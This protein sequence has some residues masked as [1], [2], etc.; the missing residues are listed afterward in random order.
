L[1]DTAGGLMNQDGFCVRS[2]VTVDA[3][4]R[5]FRTRNPLRAGVDSVFVVDRKERLLG[6]M[7][8]AHLATAPLD[9][10]TRDLLDVRAVAVKPSMPV[11]EVINLF[12]NRDLTSVAV[13]GNRGELLGQ[14]TADQVVDVMR[15]QD[16]VALRR[17]GHISARTDFFAGVFSAFVQR[18]PWLGFGLL[19]AILT[20]LIVVQ[21]ER[22]LRAAGEVAAL[23]VVVASLAGVFAVQTAL[24]TVRGLALGHIGPHNGLRLLGRSVTIALLLWGVLGSVVWL[25]AAGWSGN[26][27]MGAVAALA[28]GVSLVLAATLGFL[29]P[30]GLQRLGIDPAFAPSGLTAA[31][32]I[33]AYASVL[34]LTAWMLA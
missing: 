33:V 27:R 21:F 9:T 30:R 16:E 19:G 23:M 22:T 17:L 5:D 10:F 1:A 31:T 34:A 28:T 6:V 25:A 11:R 8:L 14:I 13:V 24:V 29:L 32:D 7:P 2:D 20:A 26:V 4:L 12:A 15:S 18:L 3:V